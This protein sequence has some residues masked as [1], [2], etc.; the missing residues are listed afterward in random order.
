MK[1][2]KT[3]PAQLPY[4]V[5]L[6]QRKAKEIGDER[7]DAAETVIKLA[8]LALNETEGLGFYRLS[9]FAVKLM[10][11]VKEFYAD[12]ERMEYWVNKRLCDMGFEISD[13]G[14]VLANVDAQGD[15]IKRGT[16]HDL[17]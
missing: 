8:C 4:A 9:R 16:P 1:R 14:T 6:Q 5:R 13:R 11:N 10:E 17:P 2:K 12:R 3:A 7:Q 15:Y